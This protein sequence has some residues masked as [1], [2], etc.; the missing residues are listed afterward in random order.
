MSSNTQSPYMFSQNGE[1]EYFGGRKIRQNVNE[2]RFKDL[3][4]PIGL[5]YQ[6]CESTECKLQEDKIIDTDKY[7][8]LF[9]SMNPKK[10]RKQK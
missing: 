10:S 1:K 6:P 9:D 3:V 8:A 7:N 5:V 2:M 4:V